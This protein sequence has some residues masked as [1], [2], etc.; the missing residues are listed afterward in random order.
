[1]RTLRSRSSTSSQIKHRGRVSLTSTT[2]GVMDIARAMAHIKWGQL[3][4]EL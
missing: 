2:V 1:M 3:A 4:V